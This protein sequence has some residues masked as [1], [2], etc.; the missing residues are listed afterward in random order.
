MACCDSLTIISFPSDDSVSGQ[1]PPI[2]ALLKRTASIKDD[3]CIQGGD[4]VKNGG[5]ND[6]GI[7]KGRHSGE[8]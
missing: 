7:V 1:L 2:G 6:G 8:G 5:V 4:S 3:Y